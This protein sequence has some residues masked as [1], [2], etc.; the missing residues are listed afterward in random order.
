MKVKMNSTTRALQGVKS[1]GTLKP[2]KA[3][4]WPNKANT[5]CSDESDLGTEKTT[6]NDV[7]IDD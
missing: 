2:G 4:V 5:T 7:F 1:E 6:I 3:N